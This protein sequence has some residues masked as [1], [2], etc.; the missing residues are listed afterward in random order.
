M[1]KH[2]KISFEVNF[3]SFCLG[4]FVSDVSFDM[5]KAFTAFKQMLFFSMRS[6]NVE[7]VYKSLKLP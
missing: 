5:K 1:K 3:T 4:M 6:T 7:L 2:Q